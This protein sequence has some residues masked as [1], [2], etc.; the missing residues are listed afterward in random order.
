MGARVSGRIGPMRRAA[1]WRNRLRARAFTADEG[2]ARRSM[3]HLEGETG[4][5]VSLRPGVPP[6]TIRVTRRGSRRSIHAASPSFRARALTC[7]MRATTGGQIGAVGPY[8]R[9]GCTRRPWR[10]SAERWKSRTFARSDRREPDA[11]ASCRTLA[12]AI[13]LQR[14]IGLASPASQS[15]RARIEAQTRRGHASISA[16]HNHVRRMRSDLRDCATRR[17]R[18]S[19]AL[20]SNTQ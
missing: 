6:A 8:Q 2:Q 17:R 20:R 15:D 12:S 10:V 4:H 1:W 5:L 9:S 18:A 14:D 13:R 19:W 11:P 3:R 7:S 16:V